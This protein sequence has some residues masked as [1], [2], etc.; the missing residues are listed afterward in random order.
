M[1]RTNLAPA[2]APPSAD[3]TQI[4]D[5]LTAATEAL[6]QAAD[7]GTVLE[8]KLFTPEEAAP[9]LGKTPN[10]VTEACTDGRIPCTYIGKS[11]RL[12]A[13][14]IREIAAAGER[15]PRQYGRRAA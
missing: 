3:L 12:T 1:T 8:L 7:G 2:E 9:L 6:A 4:L 10:W 13:G 11:P 14:H 15:R 5:R